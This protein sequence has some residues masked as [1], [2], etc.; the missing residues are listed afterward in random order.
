MSGLMGLLDLGAGALAAHTAGV[1]V[2][3]RNAAN[4]NT[5]GYSRQNV[6]LQSERGAP[7]IGG[8][9]AAGFSRVE[10]AI[11]ALRERVAAGAHGR[12]QALAAAL[13]SLERGLTSPATDVGQALAALFGG[14]ADFASAPMDAPRRASVVGSAKAVAASFRASAAAIAQARSDANSH[15][16]SLAEE[17]SGLAARI[18]AANQALSVSPDP[19]LA[20][21]RDLAARKLADLVGGQARIDGDGKMRVVIGS[22]AVL[23][24]GD[25]AATLQAAVDPNRPPDV[26]LQVVDG[27]HRIDVTASLDGGRIAGEIQFRDGGAAQASADLDALAVAFTSQVNAAHAAGAGLDG[28]A[29]RNLFVPPKGNS[30]AAAAMTVDPAIAADPRLLAAA[31]PGAGPGDN[32]AA[33]ALAALRD[34]PLAG[35]NSRSFVD[36]AIRTVGAV[37]GATRSAIAASDLDSARSDI[38]RSAR[39]S[40]SGVSIEEEL[41]RL[42]SFQHASEAAQLFLSTVND[43][44]GNLIERLQQALS[45]DGGTMRV[46]E[47]RMIELAGDAVARGRDRAAAAA[48]QA[49]GGLRVAVPSDDP[50]AWADGARANARMTQSA[51]RGTSIARARDGLIATDGALDSLGVSLSRAAEL[52]VQMANGSW[53]A[54]DRKHG[55]LEVRALRAQVLAAANSRAPDGE[56]L[57]A[58]GKGGVAPFNGAGVYVGDDQA[59]EIEIADGQQQ[60]VTPPGTLLTTA[61]GIDVLALLDQLATALDNDNLAGVRAD[62]GW[63]AGQGVR[64]SDPAPGEVRCR[65]RGPPAKAVHRARPDDVAAPVADVLHQRAVLPIGRGAPCS[66]A[67]P[68]PTAASPSSRPRRRA[69]STSSSAV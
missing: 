15:I 44:L 8:V 32:R 27:V 47:T 45:T 40:L 33:L 12:S 51:A 13:G 59:R 22:G 52:A 57:L 30:G 31:L 2:A 1:S 23:V 28:I 37:G 60:A 53:N 9:R 49:A 46:T 4:V 26:A 20:D 17:A 64:R 25:R 41:A 19:V 3:G 66:H 5:E 62:R 54:A 34:R 48:E 65:P 18:A 35:N 29:G 55:A 58:G 50:T 11:L 39:D 7:L 67:P 61:K 68:T 14:V 63:Q 36:E 56:F 16:V 43:L 42:A 21:Q 38:L 69:C 24:D 10:D 6:D